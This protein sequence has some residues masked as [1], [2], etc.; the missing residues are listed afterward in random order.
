MDL[1]R[2]PVE[3][4]PNFSLVSRLPPTITLDS[5]GD[6]DCVR[7]YEITMRY[8]EERIEYEQY[9][10][11]LLRV[12]HLIE[13]AMYDTMT[14]RISRLQ[15]LLDLHVYNYLVY[16]YSLPY[17]CPLTQPMLPNSLSYDD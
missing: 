7:H 4:M 11:A 8:L 5:H 17:R 2:L 16:G 3:T 1:T 6:Y 13:D 10:L 14:F 15:W 12:N 9:C